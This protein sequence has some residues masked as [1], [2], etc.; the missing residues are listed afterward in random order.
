LLLV[1][2]NTLAEKAFLIIILLHGLIRPLLF[3]LV[4]TTYAISNRR[5]LTIISGVLYIFPLLTFIAVI[6]FTATLPAPPFSSFLGEI[7]M[8]FRLT[9][10]FIFCLVFL[11]IGAFI[12]LVYNLNWVVT[13]IL[14]SFDSSLYSKGIVRYNILLTLFLSIM[15][16]FIFMFYFIL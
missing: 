8:F 16:S 10:N 14:K 15:Q 13:F 12:A 3:L 6:C 2:N 11:G 7:Y 9:G 4:G 1:V 5:Q